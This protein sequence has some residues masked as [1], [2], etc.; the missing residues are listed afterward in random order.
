MCAINMKM[1]K[2]T[3][4]GVDINGTEAKIFY[5]SG[6]PLSA[7]I[8]LNLLSN[9]LALDSIPEADGK[10]I[11][12]QLSDNFQLS[13]TSPKIHIPKLKMNCALFATFNIFSKLR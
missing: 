13:Q 9:I 7:P 11:N 5:R 8:G 1:D 12:M 4:F 10:T 3:L 2:F 6:E